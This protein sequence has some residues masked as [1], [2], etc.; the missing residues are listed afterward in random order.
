MNQLFGFLLAWVRGEEAELHID[1]T[2]HFGWGEIGAI[3]IIFS[4]I[5][6]IIFR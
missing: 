4:L 3:L 2:F 6:S 1:K 5:I